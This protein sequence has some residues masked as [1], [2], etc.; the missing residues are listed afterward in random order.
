MRGFVLSDDSFAD[1]LRGRRKDKTMEENEKKEEMNK[2]TDNTANGQTNEQSMNQTYG[3]AP[4]AKLKECKHCCVMIPKKAKICPN[5]KMRVKMGWLKKLLLILLLLIIIGAA[6]CGAGYYLYL[7]Q[8]SSATSVT[9]TEVISGDDSGED[10][11]VKETGAEPAAE[12]AADGDS[13]DVT[14]AQDTRTKEEQTA[15]TQTD[16]V[17]AEETAKETETEES[18]QTESDETVLPE[19]LLTPEQDEEQPVISLLEPVEN[20]KNQSKAGKSDKSDQGKKSG[21]EDKTEAGKETIEEKDAAE[22]QEDEESFKESCEQIDYKAMLRQ[23]EE[24][25]DKPTAIEVTVVAQIDGGLFDDNI[26]Y[27][28]VGED[29][30]GIERYYII[31]DDREEDA[32]LILEGDVLCIYGTL[33]DQCRLPASV[34]VTRPTV[35]AISMK[36]CELLDE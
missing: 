21:K 18:T 3:F 22:Q 25:L 17:K 31:R 32:M 13:T 19:G 34:I 15:E 29:K 2:Q 33:F 4:D 12:S 30:K 9:S 14:E 5:C 24:Y 35:P 7:Y 23:T 8:N 11:S 36:F 6:V 27:L 16:A 20:E 28:C 10:N 26:Y 1:L